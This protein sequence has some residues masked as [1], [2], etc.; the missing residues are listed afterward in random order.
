MADGFVRPLVK[1]LRWLLAGFGF[2]CK[3]VIAAWA[4]L[5]IYYS[6]LLWPPVRLTLSLAF[7]AFSIWALWLARSPRALKAATGR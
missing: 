5:A 4:A 1:P 2:L 7:V 6:N 3:L